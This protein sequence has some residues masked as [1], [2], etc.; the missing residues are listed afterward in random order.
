MLRAMAVARKL[1]RGGVIVPGR[2]SE[3]FR[4]RIGMCIA[5]GGHDFRAAAG[6]AGRHLLAVDTPE[7]F[8]DAR[9][10]R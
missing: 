8:E 7:T 6:S 4:L 5:I 2:G 1:A 10:S 9:F 3:P